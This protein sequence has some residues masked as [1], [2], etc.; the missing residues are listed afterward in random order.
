LSA[1][2]RSTNYAAKAASRPAPEHAEAEPREIVRIGARFGA[3]HRAQ[4]WGPGLTI[5]TA[6]ANVLRR[7]GPGE[8]PLAL[9]HGLVR[10]AEDWARSQGCTEFASDALIDNHVSAA[11]HRALGFQE[12]VQIRCFRKVIS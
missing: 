11:A 3:R 5:L 7:L 2:L 6:M 9:F 4:G 12:T 1:S 10:V 8:R